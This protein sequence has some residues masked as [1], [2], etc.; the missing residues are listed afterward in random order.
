MEK[1]NCFFIGSIFKL[2][3]Y[4]GKIILFNE[5]SVSLN[6]DKIKYL[7]IEKN[8]I[9]I[10][11]FLNKINSYK[12]DNFL[13]EF[14][15]INSESEAKELLKCKVYTSK[16]LIYQN[17]EVSIEKQILGFKIIDKEFG[18]LGNIQ[19]IDNQSSQALVFVKN[20]N[21]EFCF[22][23]NNQFI[24]SIEIEQQV[25]YTKIPKEIIDLN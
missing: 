7:L 12:S 9:L 6:F 24:D 23:L 18:E 11:F 21:K 8:G 13:I 4:K 17:T 2:H 1:K 20:N 10:P 14:E 15:D 22:P 25:V 5:N 19:I 3:G 16:N